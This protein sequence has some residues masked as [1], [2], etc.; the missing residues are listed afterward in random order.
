M[1]KISI[2]DIPNLS[3]PENRCL[4]LGESIPKHSSAKRSARRQRQ[5][6]CLWFSYSTVHYIHFELLVN[7]RKTVSIQKVRKLYK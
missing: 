4:V 5:K 3:S 6:G 7:T 2:I 1:N